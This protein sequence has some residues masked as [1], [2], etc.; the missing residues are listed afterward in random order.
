MVARK[1]EV[2]HLFI[3][4][5]QHHRQIIK[6]R[7]SHCTKRYQRREVFS[8]LHKRGNFWLT[9]FRAI[10]L[11]ALKSWNLARRK[12]MYGGKGGIFE[13]SSP[14]GTTWYPWKGAVWL[15]KLWWFTSMGLRNFLGLM[16][17]TTINF[18]SYHT[19]HVQRYHIIP[20]DEKLIPKIAVSSFY[21]FFSRDWDFSE[22]C[23]KSQSLAS[24][25]F[26]LWAKQLYF[27][28][29]FTQKLK[30]LKLVKTFLMR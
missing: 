11:T 8:F 29:C 13:I 1:K 7:S 15:P 4:N 2:V 16:N 14:W 23:T 5:D 24:L 21:I 3:T 6:L 20:L 17:F 25:F 18:M 9:L 22:G 27:K 30:F 19:E 12:N 10:W 26:G 28:S